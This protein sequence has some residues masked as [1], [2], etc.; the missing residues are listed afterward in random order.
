MLPQ[1][2]GLPPLRKIELRRAKS[3]SE[4]G[5]LSSRARIAKRYFGM[6]IL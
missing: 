1:L 5:I 6:E 4:M 2:L 3:Q